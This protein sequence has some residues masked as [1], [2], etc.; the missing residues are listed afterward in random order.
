[1]NKGF[2]LI[3]IL[4]TIVI[5]GGI[6]VI[7]SQSFF[8]LSRSSFRSD[9]MKQIKQSGN[10]ALQTIEKMIRESEAVV[11]VCDGNPISNKELL[12]INR[13]GSQTRLHCASDMMEG[14]AIMR[15]A[16]T[17]SSA[18]QYLTPTY[19]TLG[20][21]TCESSSL[22]FS[23]IASSRFVQSVQVKFR[24]SPV[25]IQEQPIESSSIEFQTTVNVRK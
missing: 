7:L 19:V 24:L 5:L 3:E 6:T 2:S 21:N 18:T 22:E 17:S 23:C 1:M 25:G 20:G 11:S 10:F 13:E 8:S 9:A 12:L 14:G 16:S 4:I 15:I